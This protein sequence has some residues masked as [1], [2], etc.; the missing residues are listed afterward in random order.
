M[1][2]LTADADFTFNDVNHAFDQLR[3]AAILEARTLMA[4]AG[5]KRTKTVCPHRGNPESTPAL[6]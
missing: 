2:G 1:A 6:R 4:A 5:Q 3:Y